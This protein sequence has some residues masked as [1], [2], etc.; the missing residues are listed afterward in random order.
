MLHDDV[1]TGRNDSDVGAI[2]AAVHEKP[3]ST[4]PFPT[5]RQ[6]MS[7]WANMLPAT[8]GL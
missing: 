3:P 7:L 6:K 5:V 8:R 4:W 1:A 2:T